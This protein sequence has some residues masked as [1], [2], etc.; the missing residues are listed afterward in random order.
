MAGVWSGLVSSRGGARALAGRPVWAGPVGKGWAVAT[1]AVAGA[2]QAVVVVVEVGEGGWV[3][4]VRGLVG[5]VEGVGKRSLV[6]YLDD[7][8]F[9]STYELFQLKVTPIQTRN[10]QDC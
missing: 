2:D 6:A 4:M 5:V 9:L 3:V 1:E 10:E 7:R 8:G